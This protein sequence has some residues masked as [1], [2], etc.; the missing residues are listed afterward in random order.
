MQSIH[1]DARAGPANATEQSTNPQRA[2]AKWTALSTAARAKIGGVIVEPELGIVAHAGE[3]EADADLG[4]FGLARH[5]AAEGEQAAR[6]VALDL[7][8]AAGAGTARGR[9]RQERAR[10]TEVEEDARA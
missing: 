3:G 10:A 4:R 6:A 7:E 9:G 5:A 1:I 8:R 2:S